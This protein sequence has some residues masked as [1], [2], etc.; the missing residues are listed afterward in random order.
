MN[1]A[2]K[3]IPEGYHGATPYLC[4]KDAAHAI[5]FYK[6]A[7]GA[8]ESLRLADAGGTVRHASRSKSPARPSCSPTNS[9]T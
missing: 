7:F 9:R 6:Q 3:A 8:T 4:V 2:V 5:E 1:K